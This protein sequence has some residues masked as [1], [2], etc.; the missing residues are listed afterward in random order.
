MY[1][2]TLIMNDDKIRIERVNKASVR[3]LS[4]EFYRKVFDVF[5]DPENN[6]KAGVQVIKNPME[7]R[8]Q[9]NSWFN[10]S[11]IYMYFLYYE[12]ELVGS[13]QAFEARA[14]GINSISVG[15]IVKPGNQGKGL[16]TI[17]LREATR[18]LVK[19]GYNIMLGF[20]DGN[21]ASEKLAI[22]NNYKYHA[23][24]SV[25]DIDGNFRPMTYYK[26]ESSFINESKSLLDNKSILLE[27]VVKLENGELRRVNP[28][29]I[30]LEEY[31]YFSSSPN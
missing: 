28:S 2:T 12:N 31:I 7:M 14:F 25:S 8:D 3:T 19:E 26:Y 17:M 21:Y 11:S 24:V 1:N 18:D 30:S 20:R 10:D 15:Y 13:L 4:D 5:S 22:K 23:R 27:Q 6:I 29:I 16:G 9:V